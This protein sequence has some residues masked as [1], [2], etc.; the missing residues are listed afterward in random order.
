MSPAT[1]LHVLLPLSSLD[2][3]EL[4]ALAGNITQLGPQSTLYANTTIA[5]GVK[6]VAGKA[7]TFTTS[8][9]T[10]TDTAKELADAKTTKGEDR[11]ALET[12]IF[13]FAGSAT[14][15]ATSAAELT[16]LALTPRPQVVIPKLGPPVPGNL[17]VTPPKHLKGYVDVSVNE[18]GGTRGRY[19]AQFSLDPIGTWAVLAG[20]GKSRR[21]TGASGT[22]VWVRF[23]RV[24]GQVQSD[25]GTPVL[26]VIP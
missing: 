14:N 7:A 15:V 4:L 17:T 9:K 3:A 8:C 24:R 12:E 5:N 16:G 10:V 21:V 6:G 26:I 18:V 2:D 23:A 11:V 1:K 25:W 19:A 13:A 22:K 20:T